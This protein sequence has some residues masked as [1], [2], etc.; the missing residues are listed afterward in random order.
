MGG[1][2]PLAH[3][4]VPEELSWISHAPAMG[5]VMVTLAEL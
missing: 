5:S 1:I 3:V 4:H 2:W